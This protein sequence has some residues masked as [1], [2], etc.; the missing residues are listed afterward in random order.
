MRASDQDREK[1]AKVLH[2]AMGE[3]RLTMAELDERLST[4]YAAKTIG[5]LIPVTS[6]LPVPSPVS[7][8]QPA[9]RPAAEPQRYD[10]TPGSQVSIG[11]MGGFQ[12]TGQWTVPETHNAF[13]MMGGGE[14]DLTHARFTGAHTTINCVAIMGGIEIYVPEDVAVR[15]DGIGVMGAFEDK[16]CD[17]DY[18]RTDRP[19]V[20]ITGFA[21]MGGV[22][23]RRPKRSKKKKLES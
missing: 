7:A 4:V 10:N 20:R 16:I 22:E 13:A 19:H 23:V 3:G 11:F 21:L 14:I 2:D 5:E 6:D 12:R 17:E 8:N 1:V 9:P 18:Q 15:V